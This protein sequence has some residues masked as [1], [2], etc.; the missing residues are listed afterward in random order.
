MPKVSVIIPVYNVEKYLRE[1]LNSVL[2][3][4][5][6]D[7]EVICI[8]DGSPDNSIDILREYASKDK[9]IIIIDKKNEGVGKTRNIGINIATGTF[10]AFIDPDDFYFDNDILECLYNKAIENDVLICGGEFCDYNNETN[11]YSQNYSK[12]LEGYLFEKDGIIEYKDYQF[13]YGYHRFIYNREFLINNNI[14]FPLYKRFQDPP[15]FIKA[16]ILAAKFYAIDKITYY[17][18]VCHTK[19]KWTE[20]KINDL[21]CGLVDDISFAKKYHLGKLKYYTRKRFKWHFRRIPKL[22]NLK[23]FYKCLNIM[24]VS[25]YVFVANEYIKQYIRR[26]IGY[27]K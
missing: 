3:Q 26:K 6:E 20:E 8:N 12:D 4:T 13:D 9:R 23:T 24:G 7:I 1:C 21:L 22:L 15:F 10:V 17:Y 25:I 16:M 11:E 27:K 2:S 14:Y 18:R 19:I 5:L